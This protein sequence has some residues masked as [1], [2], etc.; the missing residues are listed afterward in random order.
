MAEPQK[1]SQS[2]S[3]GPPQRALVS[4]SS[5]TAEKSVDMTGADRRLLHMEQVAD[6]G[7]INAG[8]VFDAGL[9]HRRHQS[10]LLQIALSREHQGRHLQLVKPL[11]FGDGL[12]AVITHPL[13]PLELLDAVIER[14][15][16]GTV[17]G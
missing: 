17:A 7:Q 2:P 1:L 9:D 16:S 13:A 10:E 8:Q 3:P 15:G 6:V 12:T 14:R 11:G 4:P 5:G